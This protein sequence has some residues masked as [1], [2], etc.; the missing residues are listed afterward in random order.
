MGKPRLGTAAP[1]Y[2][3][4]PDNTAS[5]PAPSPSP[6]PTGAADTA[7]A[8]AQPPFRLVR[9]GGVIPAHDVDLRS[10]PL[11]QA[12]AGYLQMAQ[13]AIDTSR[14]RNQYAAQQ[15]YQAT[16]DAL[17]ASHAR[18]DAA[19]ASMA[20]RADELQARQQDFD[21]TTKQ[22]AQTAVDPNHF[23]ASSST[24][25]KL[26]M[27]I[28]AILGGIISARQGGPNQG[29]ALINQ[30]IDRDIAA[31]EFNYNALRDRVNAKQ[32][33]F[34]MAMNKYNSVDAARA[35][36]RTAALDVA[37]QQVAQGAALWKGADAQNKADELGLQ[38]AALQKDEIGRGIAH[39]QTASYGPTF[40]DKDGL[41]YTAQ[42]MKGIKKE[43]RAHQ[44]ALEVE[45]A[46]GA[47]KMLEK[48]AD[49][50][51]KA[52]ERT[53]VTSTGEQVVAP[54]DKAAETLR[55]NASAAREVN[56]QI[57]QALQLRKSLTSLS[58]S[59]QIRARALLHSKQAH[60]TQLVQTSEGFKRLSGE[61]IGINLERIGN[62]TNFTAGADA[63]LRDLQNDVR[64]K[65][66]NY[67]RTMPGAPSSVEG[68]LP[69]SADFKPGIQ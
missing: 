24:G 15:E 38:L 22:L 10:A 44:N 31:Q 62:L 17:A 2:Q 43:D 60:L 57:E 21:A 69:S 23:W 30:M 28:S 52:G 41:T 64:Q 26:A 27:G 66:R 1:S 46:K 67:I 25:Q 5:A 54:N 50:A 53:V 4:T 18:E 11:K 6:G 49:K 68:K 55:E 48:Q 16:T 8:V 35:A 51:D 42:E 63:T 61:D 20:Q 39:V 45:G 65:E 33:A 58:P 40:V 14:A 37:Q 12:Q 47:V 56:E 59:E 36:A 29:V 13:A 32:T 7:G 19:N 9:P 34:S 3:L